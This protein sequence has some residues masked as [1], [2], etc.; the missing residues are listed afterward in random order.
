MSPEG[1]FSYIPNVVEVLL[2]LDDDYLI[3]EILYF[4]IR[5]Y[6]IGKPLKYILSLK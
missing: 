1:A 5:L 3:W 4:L 6:N 2:E